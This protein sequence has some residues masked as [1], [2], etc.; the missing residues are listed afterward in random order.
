MQ[1]QIEIDEELMQAA[2]RASGIQMAHEVI[3]LALREYVSRHAP[4]NILD[5]VGQDLIDPNYDVR[6]VRAGMNRDF[7]G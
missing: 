2:M 5:L 3:E 4:K 1:T 6:A 7:G